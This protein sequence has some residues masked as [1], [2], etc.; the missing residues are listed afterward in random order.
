ML[1][2]TYAERDWRRAQRELARATAVAPDDDVLFYNVGLL[3]RT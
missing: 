2:F 1:G 3:Y